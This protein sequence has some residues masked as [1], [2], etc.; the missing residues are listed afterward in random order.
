MIQHLIERF[1][2]DVN[3]ANI[4]SHELFMVEAL[5]R[6]HGHAGYH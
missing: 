5:R 2:P 3:L 1:G 4:E 6:K